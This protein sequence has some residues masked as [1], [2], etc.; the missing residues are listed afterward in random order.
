MKGIKKNTKKLP[1]DKTLEECFN[2]VQEL[3]DRRL[4]IDDV[5]FNCL[6]DVCIHYKAM[7]KAIEA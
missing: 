2:C 1:K 6:I 3:I 5:L 4:D 7:E